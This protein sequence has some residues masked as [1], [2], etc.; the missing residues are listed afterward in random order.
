MTY[1][2]KG[3]EKTQLK[4]DQKAA[5]LASIRDGSCEP[6]QGMT[7]EEATTMLLQDIADYDAILAGLRR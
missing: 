1:F 3:V 2:S 7:K 4:R 5:Q 6:T